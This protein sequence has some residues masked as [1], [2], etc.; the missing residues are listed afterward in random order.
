MESKRLSKGQVTYYI[1]PAQAVLFEAL[2]LKARRELAVRAV[3]CVED[4][5]RENKEQLQDIAQEMLGAAN[6][7]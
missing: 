5:L 4:I 6:R 2:G 1:D 3:E 7:L